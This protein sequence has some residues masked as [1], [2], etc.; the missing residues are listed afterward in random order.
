MGELGNLCSRVD[1][2]ENA[3]ASSVAKPPSISRG[4][5][6]EFC[7]IL[8]RSMKLPSSASDKSRDP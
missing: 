3:K 7:V 4:E 8:S 2:M 1:G 5:R 6:V